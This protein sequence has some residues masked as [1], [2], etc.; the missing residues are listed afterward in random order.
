MQRSFS[1]K[2]TLRQL[3][4][5][6]TFDQA[7][8]PFLWTYLQSLRKPPPKPPPAPP[9]PPAP[10]GGVWLNSE[11]VL[12]QGQTGHC[13]GFA[14]SQWGNCLPVDDRYK[15]A[16]GDRLYYECKDIDGEPHQEDGSYTRSAAKA[17][18]ARGRLL[19]YAFATSTSDVDFWLQ[20]KGPVPT[21]TN[22]HDAMFHPDGHGIVHPT[23]PIAGGHEYLIIGQ[24]AVGG[25]PCYVCQNSWGS[26]WGVVFQGM[27]GIFFIPKTEYGDL[28]AA[29]GDACLAL[30]VAL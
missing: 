10:T 7:S 15:N 5:D 16:D 21:G 11:P 20:T 19:A 24:A 18:V 4:D 30:E 14:W 23:G 3:A 27:H 12:D 25:L 2:E 13:V 9:T 1:E 8:L 17:M 29:D 28:L 22:W 26:G 6:K